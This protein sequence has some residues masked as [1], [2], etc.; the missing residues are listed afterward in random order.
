[1]QYVTF[2]NFKI[3]APYYGSMIC[4]KNYIIL[5]L[6]LWQWY[7]L[8]KF[9]YFTVIVWITW[10]KQSCT[11]YAYR[12]TVDG[13]FKEYLLSRLC[14]NMWIK[15]QRHYF[16]DAAAFFVT[17]IELRSHAKMSALSIK[18]EEETIV[19]VCMQRVSAILA[20]SQ[21]LFPHYEHAKI[22][23]VCSDSPS[24]LTPDTVDFLHFLG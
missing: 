24:A 4:P 22:F 16:L 6:L 21:V 17:V 19:C 18:L 11:W 10:F 9:P 15:F 20:M 1:M 3:L 23:F 14:L 5:A 13:Q 8:P 7:D 12:Q 2:K